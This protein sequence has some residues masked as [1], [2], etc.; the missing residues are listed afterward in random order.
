MSAYEPMVL[1]QRTTDVQCTYS[2]TQHSHHK[3][4]I[5]LH[6]DLIKDDV[7]RHSFRLLCAKQKNFGQ[8]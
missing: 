2:T 7:T 1:A 8:G 4:S 6:T 5:S 3:L